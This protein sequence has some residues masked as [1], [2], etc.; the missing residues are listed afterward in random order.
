MASPEE[1]RARV[2]AAM[3][4]GRTW[5]IDG[6]ADAGMVLV[7]PAPLPVMWVTP[8][9]PPAVDGLPVL[10]VGPSWSVPDTLPDD[11]V[12]EGQVDDEDDPVTPGDLGPE[13]VRVAATSLRALLRAIDAGHVLA[14]TEQRANVAA[15]LSG[16]VALGDGD[17]PAGG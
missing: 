16:L 11:A 2:D 3:I 12:G 9:V 8:E 7:N 10:R 4:E 13:D 6:P 15:C 14:T 5:P 1:V 17:G